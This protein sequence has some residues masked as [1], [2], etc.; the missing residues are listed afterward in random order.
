MVG[1]EVGEDE[2]GDTGILVGCGEGEWA[3]RFNSESKDVVSLVGL[4]RLISVAANAKEVLLHANLE[5]QVPMKD[6]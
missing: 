6:P 2:G 1:G 3:A 4:S 5:N